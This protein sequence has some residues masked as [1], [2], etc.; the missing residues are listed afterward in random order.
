[1]AF[2]PPEI[3]YQ[4][5]ISVYIVVGAMGVC[6]FCSLRLE[7]NLSAIRQVMTWDILNHLRSDY[8]LLFKFPI[9]PPTT[10][11]F[12]SRSVID[13]TANVHRPIFI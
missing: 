9:R 5:T 1:M 11:Y 2:L 13:S 4:V 7:P 12:V 8:I 3:A 6:V 10:A